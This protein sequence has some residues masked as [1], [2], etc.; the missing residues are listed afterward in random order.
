MKRHTSDEII[1]LLREAEASHESVA[2]FCR[3]KGIAEQTL[4]RDWDLEYVR[5][6]GVLLTAEAMVESD[7]HG[8]AL[9]GNTLFLMFNAHHEPVSFV[10]PGLKPR[11]CWERVVDTSEEQ[12][13]PSIPLPDRTYRLADRS[14]AVLGVR[15]PA[16]PA[17]GR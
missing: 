4:Y 7:E 1:G 17:P 10:L 3:R 5:C 14:L 9:N 16:P 15:K 11:E 8:K 12:C 2:D 6:L 13:G